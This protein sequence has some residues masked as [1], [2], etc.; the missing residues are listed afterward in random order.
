[1]Q[2]A[3]SIP[4]RM[5]MNLHKSLACAEDIKQR[6]SIEKMRAPLFGMIIWTE[7]DKVEIVKGFGDKRE[8][9]QPAESQWQCTIYILS[10]RIITVIGLFRN[11]A[12][13][14]LQIELYFGVYQS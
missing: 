6:K 5:H 4:F 7:F 12:A 9:P 3:Y 8:I 10:F 2:W 13:I 11:C 14:C 1:M